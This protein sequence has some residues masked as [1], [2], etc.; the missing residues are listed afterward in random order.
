MAKIMIY[1]ALYALKRVAKFYLKLFK[2]NE[3]TKTDYNWGTVEENL[4]T[5]NT[6]KIV[7]ILQ[8]STSQILLLVK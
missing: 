7:I 5:V 3:V 2:L 6:D 4:K 1:I 8:T